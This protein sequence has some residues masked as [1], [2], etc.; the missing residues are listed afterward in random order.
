MGLVSNSLT[1]DN[2]MDWNVLFKKRGVASLVQFQYDFS[3]T[4]VTLQTMI[5]YFTCLLLLS[6]IEAQSILLSSEVIILNLCGMLTANFSSTPR[7][8]WQWTK[9][10]NLMI[11]QLSAPNLNLLKVYPGLQ[12][13]PHTSPLTRRGSLDSHSGRHLGRGPRLAAL[14]LGLSHMGLCQSGQ[15]REDAQ[16]DGYHHY[17]ESAEQDY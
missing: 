8:F 16:T 11:F 9:K 6:Q 14:R 17:Q 5:L 10:L 12:V 15:H 13:Y 3:T 2:G 4:L 1:A 7:S